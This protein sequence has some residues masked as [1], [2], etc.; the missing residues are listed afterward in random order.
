VTSVEDAGRT[1]RL[2]AGSAEELEA[3][4][5]EHLPM[6]LRAARALGLPPDR[7]EDAVQETLLTFV[8]RATEFDGR[9]RVGTWL[10]GILLRK[11]AHARRAGR[12]EQKQDPIDDVLE[13][14]FD[15]TG[16][17]RSPPRGP[18]AGTDSARVQ[19]WL[20]ECLEDLP[21]RRRAAFVLREVQELS[22][23]E[24]CKIL[25]L[26]PNN[27]GVLLFR[28]R[29]GLRECLEARGLKGAD[30]AHV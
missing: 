24:V 20:A 17:W 10:Y 25:E 27:L 8:R 30:D 1:A 22:V 14:R 3:V 5:R 23:P 19:A 18:D 29:N 28:A 4:V 13:S 15:P 11:A 2:R 12:R 7:A 9:A 26:T 16:R 6:L 21:A